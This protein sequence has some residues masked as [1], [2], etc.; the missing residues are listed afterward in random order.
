[1]FKP[2]MSAALLLS[3]ALLSAN[4]A[5]ARDKESVTSVVVTAAVCTGAAGLATVATVFTLGFLAP[6]T[7]PSAVAACAGAAAVMDKDNKDKDNKGSDE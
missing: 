4:P 1:M 2:I 5:V 6:F 7:V 3:V